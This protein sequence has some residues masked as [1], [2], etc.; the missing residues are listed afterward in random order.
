MTG[1]EPPVGE[2]EQTLNAAKAK[3]AAPEATL[4]ML[5]DPEAK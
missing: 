1:S 2:F 4:D 5:L 3:F